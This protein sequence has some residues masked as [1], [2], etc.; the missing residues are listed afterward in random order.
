[1]LCQL[2]SGLEEDDIV[3]TKGPKFTRWI[4]ELPFNLCVLSLEELELKAA[5]HSH[6][7]QSGSQ[8]LRRSITYECDTR[9]RQGRIVSLQDLFEFVECLHVETDRRKAPILRRA[10]RLED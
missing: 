6:T 2:V 5:L 8:Q 1:M 10:L 9:C 7:S 3:G 4:K